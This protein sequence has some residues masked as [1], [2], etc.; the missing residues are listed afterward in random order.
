MFFLGPASARPCDC[1]GFACRRRIRICCDELN[2]LVP[3]CNAETDKATTL[4]WTTAFLKYIQE[5]HGDSLK[6]V[7]IQAG[8][9]P[10]SVPAAAVCASRGSC[11]TR[12]CSWGG[13]PSCTRV[14]VAA[15]MCPLTAERQARGVR[16][17][18]RGQ[19]PAPCSG[20]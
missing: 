11:G 9:G 17:G 18:G 3:F 13:S 16:P 20:F 12:P 6:K 4:Q 10:E 14:L 5:R 7:S 15:W 8:R 19:T 2:L 1:L